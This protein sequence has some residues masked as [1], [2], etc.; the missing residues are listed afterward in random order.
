M[1]A[2]W[3]LDDDGLPGTEP[4]DYDDLLAERALLRTILASGLVV[5]EPNDDL[6]V[7]TVP[8]VIVLPA[9]QASTARRVTGSMI[10][11]PR[12]RGGRRGA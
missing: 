10:P 2:W 9:A 12:N 5:S 1:S 6:H 11:S 4:A 3:L 8:E 7:L